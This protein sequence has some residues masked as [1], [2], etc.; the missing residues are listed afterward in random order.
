MDNFSLWLKRKYLE[1]QSEQGDLKTLT[2]FA[3]F[4]DVSQPAVSKW[5]NGRSLPD[6]DSVQ[7]IAVKLGWEVYDILG[8]DPPVTDKRL[9]SLMNVWEGLP[10]EVKGE[11]AEAAERAKE[12]QIPHP[13]YMV[14]AHIT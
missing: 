8:V 5:I 7:R 9:Q 13:P 11:L 1:W 10:E 14:F 2:E 6:P 12:R 3:E 4:L